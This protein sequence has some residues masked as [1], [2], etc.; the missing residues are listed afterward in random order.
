MQISVQSAFCNNSFVLLKIHNMICNVIDNMNNLFIIIMWSLHRHAPTVA[1]KVIFFQ[2]YIDCFVCYKTTQDQ[3]IKRDQH[4]RE[5]VS[6][7]WL[8]G[9]R[10]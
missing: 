1:Q 2:P 9:H 4:E 5:T 7:T 8:Y 10:S 6:S 3:L